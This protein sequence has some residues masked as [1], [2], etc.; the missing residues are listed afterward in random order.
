MLRTWP[1]RLLAMKFT[2]SVR[3]FHVPP[4]TRHLRLPAQL[5]FCAHLARPT[6]VTSPA[7]SVQ[8]VDHRVD[9][10]LE[11]QNLTAHIHCDLAR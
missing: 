2:L 4:T 11:L 5:A 3:S 9:G 6:R 10:V 1:V 8:L 7:K